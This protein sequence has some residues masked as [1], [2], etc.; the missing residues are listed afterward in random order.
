MRQLAEADGWGTTELGR[1][2]NELGGSLAA[3]TGTFAFLDEIGS[4]NGGDGIGADRTFGS[5]EDSTHHHAAATT[6]Q[7][8]W[9]GKKS[10]DTFDEVSRTIGAVAPRSPSTRPPVS[11]VS[12]QDQLRRRASSDASAI[13]TGPLDTFETAVEEV[14]TD[15]GMAH[16]DM[17][18]DDDDDSDADDSRSSSLPKRVFVFEDSDSDDF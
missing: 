17:S 16:F 5:Y 15:D 4:A 14:E 18:S 3:S 9:R 11:A 10:R 13:S 12:L 6:I 8:A 2:S 1:T 7:A